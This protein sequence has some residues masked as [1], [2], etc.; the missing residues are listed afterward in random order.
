MSAK[1]HLHLLLVASLIVFLFALVPASAEETNL[2]L[3]DIEH[4]NSKQE[5]NIDI[6][7]NNYEEIDF[8]CNLMLTIYSIDLTENIPL[9][10]S[11]TFFDVEGNDI[12]NHS[13]SFTIPISG[14]YLFNLTLL[15]EENQTLSEHYI[16]E[17]FTFYDYTEYQ[18]NEIIADYY[19]DPSDNANWIYNSEDKTIELK[20]IADSYDTGIVLGP[21]N[22]IGLANSSLTF[23]YESVKS[24]NSNYTIYSTNQFNSS[25]I[26]LLYTSPSPR[27]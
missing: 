7:V 24:L 25:E 12:Y 22:T 1:R 23:E 9:D 13:F 20:N 2:K 27:D 8:N 10:D 5:N 6:Q 14:D 3:I 18:F 16:N 17:V 19:Y 21:F 4:Q 15:I 11:I 26:C